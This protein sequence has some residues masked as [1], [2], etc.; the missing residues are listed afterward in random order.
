MDQTFYDQEFID[1]IRPDISHIEIEDGAPV[2]RIRS[3]KQMRFL[4]ESM[5]TSWEGPPS[6]QEGKRRPF[7]VLANVGLFST[8]KDPPIVPDVMVSLDVEFR[9]DL[10]RKENN[11]YFIWEFGKP[12]DL[13]IEI[14]SNRK[15]G[16]DTR[17][18]RDY[19]HIGVTYYVIFDPDHFLGRNTL[20][21][22]ELRHRAYVEM[23]ET[24]MPALG[25]GLALWHGVYEGID[26]V[27]LRWCDID[28]EV[29]PTGAELAQQERERADRERRRA[30]RAE[31][32]VESAE[33]RAE[34]ERIRAEQERIRAEQAEERAERLAAQL[35]LLGIDVI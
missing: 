34:Q 12:P 2:D 17:K 6:D 9:Q 10:T 31:E 26:D 18:L 11:T 4:A 28:G 19:A 23:N 7:V 33:E 5:N 29:L 24:W 8:L 20:R 15:G 35:K 13:V 32:Q 3:E 1:S 14:V 25:L 27:W 21:M 22:Y 16:E 30:D